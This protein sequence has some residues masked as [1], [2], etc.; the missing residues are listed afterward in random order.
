ML[1]KLARILRMIGHDAEYVREGD[2][3][4]IARRAHEEHRVLLTRDTRLAKRDD[5]AQVLFVE[6]NYPFHQARQVIRTLKLVLDPS[7]RRCVEDNGL[8]AQVDKRDVEPDVPPYIFRT[9]EDFLRCERCGR[10]FWAGSHLDG[11]RSLIHALEGAPLVRGDGD[12]QSH[13]GELTSLE[14]LLD[15]HQALE[16]LLLEHRVALMRSDIHVAMRAFR[17]FSVW[18]RRHVQDENELVLPVYAAKPP[19]D[20]YPRGAAPDIFHAEHDKILEHLSRCERSLDAL[21]RRGLEDDALRVECLGLIDREKIFVD[22]C[23]HHD[24]RERAYLYPHLERILDEREKQEL[25]ERMVGPTEPR[26]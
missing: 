19:L 6:S 13:E 15:L 20:G 21:K 2:P 4:D 7:F 14:P 16:V 12:E 17:R 18:M 26:S 23:E 11:M 3:I 10:A 25:L 22:L 1:G 24:R 9:Q 5:T 8:L